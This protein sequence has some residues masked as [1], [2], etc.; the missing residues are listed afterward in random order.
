MEK[1]RGESCFATCLMIAVFWVVM[2]VVAAIGL[3]L[4]MRWAKGG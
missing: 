2:T 4:F 3:K 1:Y